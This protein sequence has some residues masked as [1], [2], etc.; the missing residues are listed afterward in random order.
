MSYSNSLLI[1]NIAKLCQIESANTGKKWV[2]GADMAN[3]PCLDNAWVLTENGRIT[4]FGSM[5]NPNKPQHAKTIL[6]AKGGFVLPAWCDSHTHLVFA[7]TREN[8]F[9]DKIRGLSYEAIAQKGGGILNSA[10]KLQVTP[11]ETLFELA[12]QRLEEIVSMG[13]GAVEI[14]SGYGLTVEAEL[15]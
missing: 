13:T 4:S 7:A 1:E 5:D 15:K 2:A 12:W 14:K 10:Q 6:D 9:E 3:L 8:E 11:Q